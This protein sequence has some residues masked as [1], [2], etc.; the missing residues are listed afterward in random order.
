MIDYQKLDSLVPRLPP[1]F[2]R[3]QYGKAKKRGKPGNEAR[4][5]ICLEDPDLTYQ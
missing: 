2:R 1:A 4:S 3:L 5:L